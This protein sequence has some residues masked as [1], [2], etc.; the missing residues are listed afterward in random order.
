M[1]S[2]RDGRR[3]RAKTPAKAPAKAPSNVFSLPA[4]IPFDSTTGQQWNVNVAKG[5][6]GG[7][8][9]KAPTKASSSTERPP[10]DRRLPSG[11]YQV[12]TEEDMAEFFEAWTKEENR[13]I[14][15]KTNLKN[16]RQKQ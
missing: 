8:P 16:N 11:E 15:E 13:C 1:S 5:G 7:Y 10:A 3:G 9:A 14:K 4:L 6:K 2:S 12:L